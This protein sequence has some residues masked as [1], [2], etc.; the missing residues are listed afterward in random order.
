LVERKPKVFNPKKSRKYIIGLTCASITMVF[1]AIVYISLTILS[2]YSGYILY[3][4]IKSSVIAFSLL[5]GGFLLAIAMF[6]PLFARGPK[7]QGLLLLSDEAPEL[8]ELV[9]RICRDVS[10]P[11]P[12]Q[13]RVDA[14]ANAS[15]R[16]NHGLA[17]LI[18]KKYVLTIGL[19]LVSIMDIRQ[20][21]GILA[22]ELGHCAQHAGMRVSYF[23]SSINLWFMTM[24][25]KR[26][27]WRKVG[28]NT[29]SA[30]W[31]AWLAPPLAIM[32]WLAALVF[33]VG[34]KIVR[35]ILWT[36]MKLG[37]AISC[38]F[39]RQME[40]DADY[41]AAMVSGSE[42]FE[43]VLQ[44][45]SVVSQAY[46][47]VMENATVAFFRKGRLPPDF[48]RLISTEAGTI[49]IKDC[50]ND[51]SINRHKSS[52]FRTHPSDADRIQKVLELNASGISLPQVPATS[53]FTSFPQLCKDASVPLRTKLRQRC[54]QIHSFR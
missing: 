30:G 46:I 2:A 32:L 38:Y 50:L 16:F 34:S 54:S 19:P 25:Y 20:F 39:L 36:F 11:L 26:S 10:A 13:I 31:A 47:K 53:L 42:S 27:L 45:L 51:D 33:W 49:P 24:V 18:G 44:S 12:T 21:A 40:Y 17:G 29:A 6:V 15:V 35:P 4:N 52:L 48:V 5:F 43:H 7:R 23:L 8:F 14:E 9:K 28:L 41:Y 37:T 22:H 1:L 3:S